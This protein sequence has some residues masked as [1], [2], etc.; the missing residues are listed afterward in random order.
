MR[1]SGLALSSLALL[2]VTAPAAL[3]Q[4]PL[5]PEEMTVETIAPGTKKLFAIDLSLTHVVDGKIRVYDAESLKRLGTIGSGFLGMMFVP[6][7]G[8]RLY[9]STSY[10]EKLSRGK[11]SDWLEIYDSSSLALKNEI[12]ISNTRA[13]AL[14]YT[15]LMQA[16]H[17]QHWMFIQNSTPATSITVV[18]LVN[19]KQ[20]SEVPN[21]GCYGIFPSSA[22]ALKFF[23]LCGDGTLGSYVLTADGASAERKS[24]KRLFDADEDALFI[25]G[26]RDGADWIFLSF[27]GD[28][29][30][31]NAEGDTA[32][33]VEKTPM[34]ADGWRPSGYQTHA[35][36]AASGTLFVLMHPKGAEGSHKNPG[37]EIW[38]YDLKNKKLLS[39]SPTTTAFSVAVSQ[40]E[41][42]PV[43]YA[44]N[45]VEAMLMRY[46]ADPA[47][48]F[49]LTA[50]GQV[51]AG[52]LPLQVELQ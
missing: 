24:S 43:V 14:N 15:S 40:G 28:I 42:A 1:S 48:A 36:H 52:E 27:A 25:H 12:E 20:T 3:A 19:S 30:R 39:R 5:K 33:L 35:Y 50:A 41:G 17:D 46:T 32:S 9:V 10:V 7:G 37:E 29:Y 8:D 45:L 38:A 49:K 2:A 21:P 16:S 34:A 31:V 11:R 22:D 6:E 47:A 51:K 23:T 44:L 26:E 18:D 13:Q 4:E